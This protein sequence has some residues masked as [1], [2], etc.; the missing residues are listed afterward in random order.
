MLSLFKFRVSF[1]YTI[2]CKGARGDDGKPLIGPGCDLS[3]NTSIATQGTAICV[4]KKTGYFSQCQWAAGNSQV[5]TDI[6][7]FYVFRFEIAKTAHGVSRRMPIVR[8]RKVVCYSPTM[9]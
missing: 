5:F 4:S 3:C 2:S 6:I 9:R 1:S 8:M 7:L